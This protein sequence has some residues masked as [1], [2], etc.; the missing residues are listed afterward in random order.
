MAEQTEMQVL[1]NWLI[2]NTAVKA[3]IG[4][5][6]YQ[7]ISRKER[8]LMRRLDSGDG[9]LSLTRIP[10]GKNLYGKYIGYTFFLME[11]IHKDDL[12]KAQLIYRTAWEELVKARKQGATFSI[13][14]EDFTAP[15]DDALWDN[16]CLV[17]RGTLKIIWIKH[18]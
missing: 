16:K 11:A 4:T 10:M 17:T 12:T 14:V 3:L 9:L 6:I 2:T 18:N 13:A 7:G 5:N 15:E 8:D 1:I